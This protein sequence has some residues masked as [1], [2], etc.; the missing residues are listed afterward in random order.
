MVRWGGVRYYA[1]ITVSSPTT[2][3]KLLQFSLHLV[4]NWNSVGPHDAGVDQRHLVWTVQTGAADAG[5]LTPLSPEE[6]PDHRSDTNVNIQS[7]TTWDKHLFL[8]NKLYFTVKLLLTSVNEILTLEWMQLIHFLRPR[9]WT[10]DGR[11]HLHDR[12]WNMDETTQILH[13]ILSD[14]LLLSHVDRC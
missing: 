3:V 1:Q 5:I 4:V 11:P 2:E 12:Y 13:L 14:M 7:T 10:L 8:Y 6:K 9:R